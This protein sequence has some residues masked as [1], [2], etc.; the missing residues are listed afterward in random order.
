MQWG[1]IPEEIGYSK[2]T[3]TSEYRGLGITKII[4][5]N[6]DKTGKSE[7]VQTFFFDSFG[8]KT[9]LDRKS[10]RLNSSHLA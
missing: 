5:S 6:K 9:E 3:K 2:I 1:V 7:I 4:E 8:R 10:T